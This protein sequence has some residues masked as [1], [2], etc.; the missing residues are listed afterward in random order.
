MVQELAQT[1]HVSTSVLSTVLIAVLLLAGLVVGFILNRILHH[2]TRKLRNGW[3]EFVF[4]MMETLPLPLLVLAALYVGLELLDLPRQYERVI[5]KLIF[6]LLILILFYFPAKAVILFLRRMGQRR[7]HLA[8]VAQ[9]ATFLIRALFA[10]LAIII[11]LEN[12]G[13]SLT[14]V[15]TTLGVGSVAVA[16]ALQETLSNLFAGLY[17]LADRPIGPGDYIK[18]D[19]GQEGVVVRIGW[20]STVLRTLSNNHVIVPNSV[21]AKAT[22]TNYST[23][24]PRMAYVLP[25]SVA[26]GTDPT[27]VERVLL[28]VAQQAL[29]DGVEGLL[30]EPAPVARLIPGLGQSSLDFSL[31]VQIRQFTDQ[32]PVQSELRKR[33]LKRFEEEGI[34]IPFP[35]QTIQLQSKLPTTPN[36]STTSQ[37]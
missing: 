35:T 15:W 25:V 1:F 33:I 12:L 26:Y 22:I 23:P 4:S 14:A 32:F 21:L 18:L 28:E 7:P 3:G 27:R 6:A 24:E 36:V 8:Q 34:Q 37:D 2:W 10:V 5:T 19:G 31:A 29:R 16:L 20:R 13:I 11:V 9:P 17:I 30:A